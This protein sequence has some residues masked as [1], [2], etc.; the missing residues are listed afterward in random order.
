M[1]KK[2]VDPI[3]PVSAEDK[4][5]FDQ[6]VVYWQN[7]LGLSDWRIVRSKKKKTKH[8]A[9]IFDA[10]AHHRVASYGIGDDW[11]STEVIPETI[12]RTAL[13]EVLHIF[14]EGLVQAAV[15]HGAGNETLS[16]Q[17]RIIHILERILPPE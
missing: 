17:H 12:D 3:S 5:L 14:L 2:P 15:D 16:E 10:D 6:R 7:R 1:A 4:E 13:H 9:E 8:M 11:V